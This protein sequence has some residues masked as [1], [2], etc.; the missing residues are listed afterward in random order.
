MRKRPRAIPATAE[1]R[2]GLELVSGPARQIEVVAIS[3]LK[4]SPHNARTHSKKQIAM[5]AASIRRFEFL[6]PVIINRANVILAGHGRVEAAKMLKMQS[7]PCLRVEALAPEEE[8]A[9]MLADNAIALKSGYD[10]GQLV[11][12]LKELEILLPRLDVPLD[13]SI[14]GFDPAEIDALFLDFEDVHQQE[15]AEDDIGP[16]SEGPAVTQSGNL[17]LL[18]ENKLLCA[19]ACLRDSY[20]ILMG[21]VSADAVITDPP[22]NLAVRSISGR[23]AAKHR[24]FAFA[25]GEMSTAGFE[26]F[27]FKSIGQM[28]EVCKPGALIYAFCDWRSVALFCGVGS[29]LGLQ[30]VNICVWSKSTPG[31]GSFYRSAHELICVF[32]KPGAAHANNIALGRFGRSRSNIWSYASPNKFL[33]NGDDLKEHPTPKP[34]AMIGE[35]I[36][37]CTS[38]S[39]LVVDGFHG[40]GTTLLAAEKV[41]RRAYC[42]EIDRLYCD[43]A[44]RRWQKMTR[45]DAILATT[46]QTFD[47]LASQTSG[48]ALLARRR[49]SRKS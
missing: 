37:D 17:W 44:I 13:L 38:R 45:R 46:G 34:V 3:R 4:V 24:E 47:E 33:S 11:V 26:D 23:G 8:R 10:R 14:T 31:Q 22:W 39:D 43:L 7:V 40:S 1:L 5:I 29:R 16:L 36:K 27:L 9:Y 12:E 2:G 42:I 41:G 48:E 21:G 18:G 15:E 49:R 19:D 6:T 30:L 35:A 20:L 32:H 25:S 28:A